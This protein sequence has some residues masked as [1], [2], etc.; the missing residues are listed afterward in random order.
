MTTKDMIDTLSVMWRKKPSTVAISTAI[1][2]MTTLMLAGPAHA[3]AADKANLLPTQKVALQSA[4]EVGANETAVIQSCYGNAK[5]YADMNDSFTWPYSGYAKTTSSCGDI[6]LKPSDRGVYAQVCYR[7]TGTCN[8]LKWVP[9][10]SWK[11]IA[12]NVLDGTEFYV[13]F[14][15]RGAGLVAY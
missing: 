9:V 13:D 14:D 11:V 15:R 3:S 10:G 4:P 6:N 12:S 5:S 2:C 1:A 7:R 8:G